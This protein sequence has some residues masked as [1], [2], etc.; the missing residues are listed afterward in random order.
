MTKK[1][2]IQQFFNA[3][4]EVGKLKLPSGWVISI[5]ETRYS[6]HGGHVSV[7]R[8]EDGRET[9]IS[10]DLVGRVLDAGGRSKEETKEAKAALL[11]WL[12]EEE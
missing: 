11:A 8:F 12:E 2:I 5:H 9:S 1:E 7:W 10:F 4:T 6:N 3:S